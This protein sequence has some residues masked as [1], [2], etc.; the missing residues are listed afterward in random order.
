MVLNISGNIKNS[1]RRTQSWGFEINYKIKENDDN[2]DKDK[3][4]DKINV[5]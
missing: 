3:K 5:Q 1:N 4:F 2:Q